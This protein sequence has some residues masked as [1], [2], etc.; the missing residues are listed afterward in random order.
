MICE[1]VSKGWARL[2]E[3]AQWAKSVQ[4]VKWAEGHVASVPE[5]STAIAGYDDSIFNCAMRAACQQGPF[6]SSALLGEI[7]LV[8]RLTLPLLCLLLLLRGMWFRDD[9]VLCTVPRQDIHS[10]HTVAGDVYR[11]KQLLLTTFDSSW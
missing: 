2:Q 3:W 8:P 11:R 9:C 5:P 6:F 4:S 1:E 7:A 10:N